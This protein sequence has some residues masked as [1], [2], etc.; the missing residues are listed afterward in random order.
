MAT[1]E[2][3][4]SGD[5]TRSL[6]LMWGGGER[7]TRGPKPALTLE[8]IIIAAVRLAD[9][10][11]IAAVSMRRLSTELGT[12]TMSLYRYV[13]GKAELLDLM[14]NHVQAPT[15]DEEPYR[16][17]WRA[18]LAAYGRG[19]LEQH[20]KHPWL[21][22]VNQ[23]RPVLGPSAVG[24]L[25]RV[26]TYIKPMGLTDPELISVLIMVEGYVSGVA[27]NHVHA[28]QAA[29][30]SQLSDEAFWEAQRPVLDRIM[31]SG[32]YPLIAGLSED[33]FGS[34]FDHFEFGLQRIL[35]GLEVLVERRKQ[36]AEG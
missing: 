7:P 13:P 24:G 27:R 17:G 5:I 29:A 15:D 16:G 10:E 22:Q 33:S 28:A 21:L 19:T 32:K 25:E 1:T 6:E 20:R 14:L 4:G 23:A 12:G 31:Q 18:A 30:D 11:G 8:R 9:A 36:D 26:L 35:D 3:S 2:T 34:D